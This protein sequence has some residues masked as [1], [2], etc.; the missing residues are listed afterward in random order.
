M[1]PET[2][3]K[4]KLWIARAFQIFIGIFLLIAVIVVIVGNT[5][6]ANTA[7]LVQN[8]SGFLLR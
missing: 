2:S 6:Y 1:D 7:S 8:G 4:V 3:E 5:M